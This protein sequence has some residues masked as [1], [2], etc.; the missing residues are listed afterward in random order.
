M[1][2]GCCG[3]FRVMCSVSFSPHIIVACRTNSLFHVLCD[4]G[5]YFHFS[6]F[7]Y[8]AHGK[9][10]ARIPL[11]SFVLFVGLPYRPDLSNHIIPAERWVSASPSEL[12]A[13]LITTNEYPLTETVPL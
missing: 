4:Q 1:F 10:Q 12:V 6:C 11:G 9:L 3:V 7:T 2:H 5:F 8:I 13:S